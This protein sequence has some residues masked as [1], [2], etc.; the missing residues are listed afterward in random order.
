MQGRIRLFSEQDLPRLRE[1]SALCYDG[2]DFLPSVALKYL[3][4]PDVVFY[5]L[6]DGTGVLQA[7]SITVWMEE[8]DGQV[9]CYLMGLRV[10]LES[11]KRGLAAALIQH[12]LVEA[13]KRPNVVKARFVRDAKVQATQRLAASCGF[14][15]VAF[16]PVLRWEGD[17]L[18]TQ[19]S[20]LMS[21]AGASALD[22]QPVQTLL[23]LE[24][25]I[26]RHFKHQLVI[27]WR[28]FFLFFFCVI[29]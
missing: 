24:N 9:V 2:R 8:D 7:V 6:E 1:I 19:C 21:E 26:G 29:Y 23:E 5:A 15:F 3:S 11:R 25:E 20:L 4:R 28:L 13:E 17:V 27:T 12:Q 14:D 10:A 18:F 22:V 16:L